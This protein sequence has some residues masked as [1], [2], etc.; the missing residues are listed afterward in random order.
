MQ[1]ASLYPVRPALQSATGVIPVRRRAGPSVTGFVPG[2][3]VSS[4][5]IAVSQTAPAS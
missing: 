5:A 1:D 2:A 4:A 3:E